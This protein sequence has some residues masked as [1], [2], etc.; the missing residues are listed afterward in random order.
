MRPP[1]K[2]AVHAFTLIELLTVIAIIAILMG[3]LFPALSTVKESARKTQAK[4][5]LTQICT[6]VTAF[7]TEYSKYPVPPGTTADYYDY[8]SKNTN[9]KLFNVLRA[10]TNGDPSGLNPR[11]IVFISPPLA[12]PTTQRGGIIPTGESNAGCYYD[13]WGSPYYVRIDSNYDNQFP[14]PYSS[15][16]GSTTL[17][18]GV[19]SW[20]LGKNKK[21][22]SGTFGTGDA[23][24]DVLSW[25]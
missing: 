10:V 17:N 18:A 22:G 23:S 11:Q 4:N 19:V 15:G 14:N 1:K 5:D 21:G 3:L 20:S 12:K 16:A 13:P 9:D 2:L 25:Q 24:D 8:G 7:Y 6:A